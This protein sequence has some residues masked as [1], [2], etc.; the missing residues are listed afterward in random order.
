[1]FARLR[2]YAGALLGHRAIV[3][4][5]LALV[6]AQLGYRAWALSGSWF[7]FDDLAFMSRAM[8]LPFGWHYL[9]ES[10]GGHLMPAGF[11]ATWLLTKWAVYDWT[12][13]WVV[14]LALQGLAGVGM[15]RLLLSC[16]GRRP[17][18]LVLLTGYLAYVFT[19]PAGLWWAAGINQLPLQVALVFGLHAH[20]AYLRT[21]RIRHLVATLAWTTAGLLFYEKTLLLF[22]VYAIL[23]LG[24]FCTGN[25][26]ERLRGL[27]SGYRAG[28]VAH[29]VLAAGYLAAYVA[30]GLDF[31]PSNSGGQSWTP[32]VWNLV[33]VACLPAV[34]GGPLT[35]EPLTVG[36]IADPSQLVQ[37]AS[38]LLVGGVAWYGQRT[39]T[40]SARA[41]W[42]LAF[43]LFANVALLASARA[44]IVGPDI[45]REYRYQTES[46]ALFV[47]C[48]GLA[49]LPL[50]GAVEVNEL[51][52]DVPR[53]YERRSLVALATL[54]VTTV[55]MVSSTRYVDLWQ[56]RNPTRAYIDEVRHSL[57]TAPDPPVP[58]VDTGVPTSLLW[59]FRYPENA[60]S[61]L[62]R[63]WASETRY[64]RQSIDRLY[65]FD[66]QGRLAPVVIPPTRRMV[67]AA[68]CGY[69]L[70]G[71][72]TRIPL[73]GPVI[74]GGWWIQMGYASPR[75]VSLRVT[76]GDDVHDLD[77]PKGLHNV[78]VQASGQFQA[79]TVSG[80]P[81][82][83]DLCV[84]DVTLG[85]PVPGV[86]AP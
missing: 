28:I 69:P 64:P 65:M 30:W 62:F 51:R 16:F 41:W 32:I 43:T 50:R 34:V 68:G 10:Y 4:V 33:A 20:L 21:A 3:L 52:P 27:W 7:Y 59:A 37:L 40:L 13:W 78:F 73:D 75:P 54:A 39:R 2:R 36:S 29:S 60:Y 45:A 84:V 19:L 44:N 63:P 24:W 15:L 23:A 55:A 9:F 38:W 58:L 49:F 53:S 48:L 8:N 56:Q 77:L 46:G 18:V 57:A 76:A 80:Y 31:S 42:L 25:T 12:P 6:A 26:P 85:I 83:N 1:M 82:R 81:R 72:R 35:W 79:V 71:A 70:T 67:P 47:L 17:F 86:T 66:D 5:G 14:L 11:A 74:G 22:G 61:H